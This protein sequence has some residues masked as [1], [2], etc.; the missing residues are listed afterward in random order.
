[1]FSLVCFNCNLEVGETSD[2][3]KQRAVARVIHSKRHAT[4]TGTTEAT[5][6]GTSE[7]YARIGIHDWNV[8]E[9]FTIMHSG[10]SLTYIVMSEN[11]Y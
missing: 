4:P 8:S 1:M 9:W 2:K 11:G 5:P 6:T 3:L 7:V 10:M